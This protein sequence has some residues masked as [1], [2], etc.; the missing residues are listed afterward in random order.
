MKIYHRWIAAAA[1]LAAL[2]LPL[3]ISAA[4][5]T[6]T[7]RTTNMTQF[8]DNWKARYLV[9]N[10][11]VTD[12]TQYYV[13]YSNEH[14]SGNGSV[15]VTVSEAHG[16]GM[17]ITASM[18]A[19]DPQAQE[20][21]DGMVRYYQAHPSEIGKH[22]MA[23]QQSDN[24]S[25]LVEEDG[26][27]SASDGDMD[28]AY[29]LLLADTVWGS[30]GAYNYHDMAISVL[31]DIMEYEVNHNTW[32]INL[33]DWAHW[34]EEGDQYYGAT[35]SSDFFL[36]YYPVF[37]EVTGDDNWMKVYDSTN[38]II[39]SVVEQYGTG[40]LPDFLIPNENGG[41]MPAPKNFLEDVTDG[42]YAYNSCRTPWRIGM[43]YLVN[44]N[45]TAKKCLDA[46]NTFIINKTGGDPWEI[47]AGYTLDGT[48]TQDYDDLCF[49]AP[50][51]IAAK[52]GTD[53]DWEN[54]LRDCIL[55]YGDDVYY[56]DTI[57]MLC[58]I[59]DADAWIV[60]EKQ[61]DQTET[62]AETTTE[63]SEETT[64][65]TTAVPQNTLGDI[66][67]DGQTTLADIVLLLQYL[68]GNET[69]SQEQT[70]RADMQQDGIVN[71]MDLAVL[72]Q[73]LVQ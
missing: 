25:A 2:Q 53:T 21:F 11:Y 13:Y 17:L 29:A 8:Y 30:D 24:G 68:L 55:E 15:A 73:T 50:F 39:D 4:A 58:L 56:G 36:Q 7:G 31:H 6:D 22:L 27:D 60:P 49:T 14:Y 33:G 10:T 65:E 23:W 40:L 43:D 32:T 66:N 12:E 71:G 61:P 44:K 37:A 1:A 48:A 20:L 54:E 57:K 42:Q 67:L 51:L 59:A 38:A 3:N 52:C 9:Q 41:Y 35:R 62:T 46:M 69:L 18:A 64:T 19:Y 72:R 70:V 28:I 34:E 63:T 26:A 16:Y 5:Q 45:A 47:R